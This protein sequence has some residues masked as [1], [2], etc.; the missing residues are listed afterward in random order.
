M[1]T[2]TDTKNQRPSE[3]K[4]PEEIN[5]AKEAFKELDER[6]LIEPLNEAPDGIDDLQEKAA[7]VSSVDR[8]ADEQEIPFE[9]IAAQAGDD[10]EMGETENDFAALTDEDENENVNSTLPEDEG[11]TETVHKQKDT[12][13]NNNGN[14]TTD[15]KIPDESTK[16]SAKAIT[17]LKSTTDIPI[18]KAVVRGPATTR[19]LIAAA[20]VILIIAGYVIYNNPALVGF[21]AEESAPQVVKAE[22]GQRVESATVQVQPPKP[23]GKQQI[24]LSKLDEIE[25]LREKLLAKKEEIY[26]LKLHYLNGIAE[27]KDHIG[28]EIQGAG[29]ASLTQA[30]KNK[31]IEL[32]LRTIQRRQN[33]IRE[34]E[35]PNQWAHLGSEELLFLK[36]K[37][38]LDLQMADVASGID[39]DRHIRYMNAALQKYQPSAEKLSVDPLPVELTPLENIWD[40]I[41]EQQA[42]ERLTPVKAEDEKIISEICSGD[43]KRIAELTAITTEAA[44]CLVRMKSSNL[45]LNGLTQL[46]PEDAKYLFQWQGNWICMNSI[47]E[48]SPAVA[49]YLF[50]WNGNWISLNGLTEFPPELAVYLMEWKGNQ[51]EL[52]GLTY[53][54]SKPD[55][56]ALKHLA[57]WETMGGK[58][59][60]SDGVRKEMARVM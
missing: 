42:A 10:A 39:L 49:Q 2:A 29:I 16:S 25:H 15:S 19:K 56:K 18:K 35:K 54:A 11:S 27:L 22:S 24:Y 34:L 52:M 40:Q 43:F 32:N 47:K 36:R 28:R 13:E 48:I 7:T 38:E 51:L 23:A 12:L 9:G 5:P 60:V 21:K 45:F 50:K 20:T 26:R 1:E 46:S 3:I 59:F 31:H 4:P 37:A 58:L 8:D 41:I 55:R 17:P 33:Y 14:K 44:K 53:D 6:D 30:L 57:L